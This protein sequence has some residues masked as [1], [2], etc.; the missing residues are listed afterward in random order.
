MRKARHSKTQLLSKRQ[1]KALMLVIS[2]LIANGIIVSLFTIGR[3]QINNGSYSFYYTGDQ[4]AYS[5]IEFRTSG[6]TYFFPN[7]EVHM[8][9]TSKFGN[10]LENVSIFVSTDNSTWTKLPTTDGKHDVPLGTLPLNDYSPLIV[11]VKSFG[12]ENVT[13]GA[14]SS[15]VLTLLNQCNISCYYVQS[16]SS[17]SL[18][19]LI[20]VWV[21]V[22][23]FVLQILDFL[24]R[25]N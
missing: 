18:V 11:Y 7:A 10:A 20:L 24:F 8:E 9:L 1:S 19:V 25:K 3:A 21:A 4:A 14:Q 15:P 13:L 17:E 12:P 6:P 2:I 5:S 16:V 23:S 22:L